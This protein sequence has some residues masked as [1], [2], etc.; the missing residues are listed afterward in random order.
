MKCLV[1][2]A[3]Q[4]LDTLDEVVV[5]C[6]RTRDSD[7]IAFLESVIADQMRRHLSRNANNRNRVTERVGQ[8]GDRVGGTGTGR[9]QHAPDFAG[10][11]G[12]AFRGVHRALL[13]PDQDVT[14]LVLRE[15]CIVD[16]QHRSARIAEHVLD[17]LVGKRLNHHLGAGHFPCH[18]VS[19]HGR[20]LTP[21]K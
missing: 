20:R 5:L 2:S 1:Q 14:Y 13:V 3:R 21:K 12:I 15:N 19:F 8:P 16:R 6:A 4:I 18:A 9:H 11:A 10:R 17:V 7:R